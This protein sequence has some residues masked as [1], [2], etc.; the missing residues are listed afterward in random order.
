MGYERAMDPIATYR[1]YLE[2]KPTDRFAL[3]SLALAYKKAGQF[4]EAELA[5]AA[6]LTEHPQSGAGHYQHGL[7]YAE[8]ERDEEALNAW[9]SGLKAL[10]GANDAESRRSRSEIEGAID[11]LDLD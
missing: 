9:N 11:D 4:E 2:K 5:F 6:L 1:Q 8:A 7:L 10:R 3:Y